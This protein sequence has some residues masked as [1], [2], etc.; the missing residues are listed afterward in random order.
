MELRTAVVYLQNVCLL[1]IL[2]EEK[3]VRAILSFIIL[4]TNPGC[5]QP[6]NAEAV[7]EKVKFHKG[8]PLITCKDLGIVFKK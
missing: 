7:E 2:R 4:Q 8:N 6:I 1:K 3:S 5:S